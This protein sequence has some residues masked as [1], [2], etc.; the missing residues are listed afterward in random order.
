LKKIKEDEEIEQF[1]F[2]PQ[3][4]QNYEDEYYP[5]GTDRRE[6]WAKSLEKSKYLILFR[7]FFRK[8]ITS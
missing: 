2:R 3:I 8:K 7:I 4:N 5:E 1:S 6:I